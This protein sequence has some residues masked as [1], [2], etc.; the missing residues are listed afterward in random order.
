MRTRS[1]ELSATDESTIIAKP[2][3]DAIVMKDSHYNGCLV[4]PSSTNESDGFQVFCETND[5]LD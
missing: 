1:R 4:D 3:L 2:F 5:L